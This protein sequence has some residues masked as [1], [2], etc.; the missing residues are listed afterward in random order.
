M[1]AIGVWVLGSRAVHQIPLGV[2]APPDVDDLHLD[3]ADDIEEV[4]RQR[5]WGRGPAFQDL[6]A[7]VIDSEQPRLPSVVVN[8]SEDVWTVSGRV[9]D[10]G[11]GLAVDR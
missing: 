1:E 2:I 8:G 3:E 6:L 9:T 5:G 10:V 7:R 11:R 4:R